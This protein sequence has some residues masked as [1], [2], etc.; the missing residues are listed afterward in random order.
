MRRSCSQGQRDWLFDDF[1]IALGEQ[2]AVDVL[3]SLLSAINQHD[4][5]QDIVVMHLCDCFGVD[6]VRISG[7][8]VD[9]L[10]A[11]VLELAHEVGC[12]DTTLAQLFRNIEVSSSRVFALQ[13]AELDALIRLNHGHI[14]SLELLVLS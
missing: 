7:Q 5:E 12:L 2:L 11:L 8:L 10:V 13:L 6:W 3:D 9:L 1:E 4:L 14:I